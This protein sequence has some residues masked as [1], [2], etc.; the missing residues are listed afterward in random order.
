MR[1]ARVPQISFLAMMRRLATRYPVAEPA[2]V[3]LYRGRTMGVSTVCFLR[4]FR[5]RHGSSKHTPLDALQSRLL[6]ELRRDGVTVVPVDELVGAGTT[7][8]LIA[9]AHA[10][11]GTPTVQAQIEDRRGASGNKEFMIRAFGEPPIVPAEDPFLAIVLGE[12]ILPLVDHYLGSTKLQSVNLWYSLP[13]TTGTPATSSQLWHRDYDDRTILKCFLYL[14]DVDADMGAFEYIRESQPGGRYVKE[15]PQRPPFGST[16]PAGSVEAV[17]PLG[18]HFQATGRA[19]TLVLCDTTGLHK[20]GRSTSDPRIIYYAAFT[21]DA[22][23]EKP[24]LRVT[25]HLRGLSARALS[26]TRCIKAVPRAI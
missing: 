14:V 23:V 11:L 15:F 9:A 3:A 12:R 7:D 1:Q 21:T 6:G 13:V 2:V 18:Q 8:H 20:G 26:A 25:G 17:I 24:L 22:A 4:K 10:A 19:G 5:R 16:P